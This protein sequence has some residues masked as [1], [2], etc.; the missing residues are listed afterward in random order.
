MQY[1]HNYIEKSSYWIYAA[2]DWSGSSVWWID[3]KRIYKYWKA[4]L[5]NHCITF[6]LNWLQFG[7]FDIYLPVIQSPMLFPSPRGYDAIVVLSYLVPCPVAG[8]AT[9]NV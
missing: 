1:D 9:V 5:V 2:N 7:C 8:A 3:N 6:P 4:N